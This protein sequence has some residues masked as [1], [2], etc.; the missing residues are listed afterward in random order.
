VLNG[1]GARVD[2]SLDGG[3]QRFTSD[4]R[5]RQST[6]ERV[7]RARGV[8]YM[9][10]VGGKVPNSGRIANTRSLVSKGDDNGSAPRGELSGDLVRIERRRDGK[11][12]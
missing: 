4:E 6:G 3:V 12:R 5:G 8:D 10:L 11:S 9:N 1:D 2:P 7:A